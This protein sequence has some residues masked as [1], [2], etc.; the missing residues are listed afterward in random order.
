MPAPLCPSKREVVEDA[1]SRSVDISAI[2][3]VVGVSIRQVAK[4]KRNI[5]K[6]G[7]SRKPREK[8]M[9]RPKKLKEGME[10]VIVSSTW[11]WAFRIGL[12]TDWRLVAD[13]DVGY[14]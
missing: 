8:T 2:S 1:L 12:V 10:E 4:M 13:Q 5:E 3:H 6:Y 7:S 9:G 14:E 11:E